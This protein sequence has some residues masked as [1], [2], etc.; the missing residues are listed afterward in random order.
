MIKKVLF[1]ILCI[2]VLNLFC[3]SAKADLLPRYMDSVGNYG[4]GLY[5][6]DNKV[7]IYAN[8]QLNQ[9][10]DTIYKDTS[11]IVSAKNIV[12]P[13]NSIIAYVSDKN[14][15]AFV[16][17]EETDNALQII[18]DQKTGYKGWVQRPA[19]SNYLSWFEFM[20]K[21]GKEKGIY[22]LKDI[23]EKYKK[24]HTAP[25]KDSQILEDCY[26]SSE[27]IK[28]IKIAGNWMLVKVIDFD[29]SAVPG[30]IKWRD[31][32]GRIFVF[33]DFESGDL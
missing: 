25:S 26:Y 16:V 3:L 10:K 4:I 6:A 12:E 27:N 18:T 2:F 33:P 30:W 19:E 14:L 32:N 21:Y 11:G 17:S 22:F 28:L 7:Q 31:E 24:L 13:L 1:L 20:N 9:L 5:L 23:D 15:I 29:K 8:P